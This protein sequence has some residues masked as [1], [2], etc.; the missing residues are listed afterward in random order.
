MLHIL[1]ERNSDWTSWI[2]IIELI[3]TKMIRVQHLRLY[4]LIYTLSVC[5][6]VFKRFPLLYFIPFLFNFIRKCLSW[7][8]SLNLFEVQRLIFIEN[9][10]YAENEF[11]NHHICNL[12]HF[13]W[14][15]CNFISPEPTRCSSSYCLF[16]LYTSIRNETYSKDFFSLKRLTYK[17]HEISQTYINIQ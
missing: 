17:I 3:K 8:N 14:V 12:K 5:M 2:Q 10:T 1:Y 6:F 4:C 11:R 16:V 13:D 15:W 9:V 7:P